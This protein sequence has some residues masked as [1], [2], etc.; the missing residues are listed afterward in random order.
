MKCILMASFAFTCLAS[1]VCAETPT[2]VDPDNFIRAES[3][4][5]FSNFVKDGSFGKFHHV[6]VPAEIEHQSVIRLNRDTL[7]SSAVFDLDAGP[8]TVTFPDPGNRFM[9][10][11]IIDE[12]QYVHGVIYMPGRYTLDR[13]QIGTRYVAVL[14]RT[15][16]DPSDAT[17]LPK[18]HALQDKLKADQARVGKFEIP[19]WDKVSQAKVRQGLAILRLS[20]T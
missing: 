10:M 14:I 19:N 9:S 8:A 11:E 5:Y 6:R 17:D 16:V 13:K 7:Y 4:M 18:V 1:L 12:D 15:L 20:L 3:D 2:P